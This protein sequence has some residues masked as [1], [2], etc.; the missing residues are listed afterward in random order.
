MNVD[1]RGEAT[2]PSKNWVK[3]ANL[4]IFLLFLAG[5]CGKCEITTNYVIVVPKEMKTNVL[6]SET[7]IS[8]SIL[9]LVR[10]EI[11]ATGTFLSMRIFKMKPT[12]N[13]NAKS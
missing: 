10:V 3:W 7:F 13:I 4:G 12:Q 8:H 5:R 11:M 6:Q 9:F 2:A 1:S